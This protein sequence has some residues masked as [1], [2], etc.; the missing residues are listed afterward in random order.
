MK[1]YLNNLIRT[2]YVEYDS[3][4]ERRFRAFLESIQERADYYSVM[5]ELVERNPLL[6]IDYLRRAYLLTG[7][8]KHWR[9][10]HYG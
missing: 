9:S 4:F 2:E 8:R 6:A 10:I 1:I 7:D 3:D 5:A